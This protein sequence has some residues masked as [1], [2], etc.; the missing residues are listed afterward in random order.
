MM[1]SQYRDIFGIPYKGIHSYRIGSFAA[2]DLIGTIII[3]SLL[4]YYFIKHDILGSLIGVLGLLLLS[5]I[6]HY[7]F[8]VDTSLNMLLFGKHIE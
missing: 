2:V 5:I 6:I 4:G 7:I 8:T 3:G 1:L